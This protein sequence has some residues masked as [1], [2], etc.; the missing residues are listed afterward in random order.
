MELTRVRAGGVSNFLSSTLRGTS[1]SSISYLHRRFSCQGSIQTEISYPAT[2][3]RRY[4][5]SRKAGHR[6][7]STQATTPEIDLK[8]IKKKA[9]TTGFKIRKVG[10]GPFTRVLTIETHFPSDSRVTVSLSAFHA[11]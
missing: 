3:T 5:Y 8:S 1:G 2:E 10:H 7:V 9:T 4:L 6:R 11:V